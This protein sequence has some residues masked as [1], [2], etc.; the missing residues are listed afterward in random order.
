MVLTFL[1][2]LVSYFLESDLRHANG[3]GE[4]ID[5]ARLLRRSQFALRLFQGFLAF[6]V[7]VFDLD[8]R[9]A[10]LV[11]NNSRCHDGLCPFRKRQVC[12]ILPIDGPHQWV[13]RYIDIE[14]A[15]VRH[16]R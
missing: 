3:D 2:L 10:R 1:G 8:H 9:M 4:F 6:L 14:E 7:K 16:P 5:G 15:Q 12:C 11:D 13:G